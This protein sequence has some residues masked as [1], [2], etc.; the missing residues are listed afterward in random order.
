MTCPY[1]N[2]RNVSHAAICNQCGII[3]KLGKT[4]RFVPQSEDGPGRFAFIRALLPGNRLKGQQAALQTRLTE[5][6]TEIQERADKDLKDPERAA[7][8]RLSLGALTLL[9]GEIEKSVQWFQ[10][11]QQTGNVEVEFYNNTGIAL[12]RRGA[13]PQAVDMFD[14]AVRVSPAAVPPRANFAHLFVDSGVDE[15]PE[16]GAAALSEIQR[17]LALEPKNPTLYNRLGLIFCRERRLDEAAQQFRQALAMAGSDAAAQADA[18]N[19]VGMALCLS[20]DIPAAMQ[21]FQ[22]ALQADPNHAHALCNQSLVQ[23]QES[24]TGSGLEKLGRAART[25]PVSGP[26]RA[27][28]GYGL[29]RVGAVNEGILELKEA[30]GMNTHLFQAAYNLGKAYADHDA[31]DIAERYL[32]RAL[33]FSPRSG[34][35]LTALGVIKTRQRMFPQAIGYFQSA[36]KIWPQRALS[37]SN[38]GIALGLS[39]DYHEASLHLRKAAELDPKDPHIPAQAGWVHLMQDNLTS[40]LDELGIAVGLD[41]HISEVQNNYGICYIALNKPDLALTRFKLAL[42]LNPEFH[43][44]HYQ[45][46]YAYANLKNVD[47]ALREWEITARY[48]PAN[49]DCHVN[50]GVLLYQKGQI[51][52]A[53]AE[54]RHVIV[55]RQNRMEDFSNLGL[56]YAK[57]GMNIQ[58][59]ARN[60]QD[61]RMKQA[62]DR[63]KQAIDM[64]DRALVIDPR[65]VMLHSNLGLACFFASRTEES[66]REWGLVSQ[67][68]PAYAR[69]RGK[70]QQSEFDDSQIALV[71][72]LIPE[73]AASL[74]AKTGPY[75]PRF[76][77][78]YDTEE[79]DYLLSEPKLVKLW[80]MRRESR[81]MDRDVNAL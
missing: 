41:Q 47:S 30:I 13:L 69:R 31:L 38:L 54:F 32:A 52:E 22:C 75:L 21:A 57:S 36:V 49:A 39:G 64:F 66:M 7:S 16:A 15:D 9:Q 35:A 62:L 80:E 71:P 78:G 6:V 79:W 33:Q 23:M 2:F 37:R 5:L 42:E 19:N 74:P 4:S 20:G 70:R 29:C 3:L 10:Q 8:A 60:P 17:A 45:W 59:T 55:L 18:Q 43:A 76:L 40:G 77:S 81:R 34:E 46:G 1:C 68:D 26:V 14:H 67:I 58:K 27:N 51:D 24:A 50:R 28:Y 72:F 73:R 25:D 63:H 61:P 53:I 12:A 44:V 65:N 11:A 56:A 48:E